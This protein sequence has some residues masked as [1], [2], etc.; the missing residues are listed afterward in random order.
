[1]KS[2]ILQGKA[3][4]FEMNKRKPFKLSPGGAGMA[5]IGSIQQCGRP[6][7][8]AVQVC[9]LVNYYINSSCQVEQSHNTYVSMAVTEDNLFSG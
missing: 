9:Q 7:M 1:M 6:N 3:V 4:V 2:I 5:C 8:V